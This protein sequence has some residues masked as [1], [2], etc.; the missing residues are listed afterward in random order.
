[1]EAPCGST[2]LEGKIS[3]KIPVK[4]FISAGQCRSVVQNNSGIRVD[5]N[6]LL[7]SL[8]SKSGATK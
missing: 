5:T 1:M 7:A 3:G 2:S 4:F 8:P 6:V